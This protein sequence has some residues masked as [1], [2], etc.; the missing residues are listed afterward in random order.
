MEL[1]TQRSGVLDF[2]FVF[3]HDRLSLWRRAGVVERGALE[4]R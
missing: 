4:K 2:P 1:A 3:W